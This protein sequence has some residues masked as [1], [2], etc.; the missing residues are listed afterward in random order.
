[1]AHNW[2]NT[3]TQCLLSH[4]Y[5]RLRRHMNYTLM[6]VTLTVYNYNHNC[7]ISEA[8]LL[9]MCMPLSA[10]I[11]AILVWL[12]QWCPDSSASSPSVMKNTQWLC[13]HTI[14]MR[15]PGETINVHGILQQEIITVRNIKILAINI[16]LT[17]H[18]PTELLSQLCL[19][20]QRWTCSSLAS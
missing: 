5:Q 4:T 10:P 17:T 9:Q 6:A 3:N 1:M 16:S 12:F 13:W 11:L 19:A 20:A 14:R 18:I 15:C 7:K 8:W 2:Y